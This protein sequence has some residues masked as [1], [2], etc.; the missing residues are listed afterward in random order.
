MENVHQH[1]SVSSVFEYFSKCITL[2]KDRIVKL[3]YTKV[4]TNFK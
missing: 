4:Y 2:Y 3:R 1:Y